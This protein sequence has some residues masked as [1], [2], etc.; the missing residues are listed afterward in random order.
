MLK[1]SLVVPALAVA[2]VSALASLGVVV[3]SPAAHGV[4]NVAVCVKGT[5]QFQSGLAS[6]DS[7]SGNTAVAVGAFSDA[8][9]VGGK[10]NTAT[11]VGAFAGA[12][13]VNGT[14]N[15][16]TAVGSANALAGSGT[17]NSATAVGNNTVAAVAGGNKNSAIAAAD[18][19]SSTPPLL[20]GSK[21]NF[22][23]P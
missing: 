19:C 14:K 22:T 23:C 3:D 12:T 9:G 2:G 5:Q 17:A 1:R 18:G 20:S 4:A 16:S 7:A 15:R 21:Q 6:C 10:K 8:G 13:T 11:A